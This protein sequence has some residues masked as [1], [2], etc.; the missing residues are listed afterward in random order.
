[1]F[2]R[3]LELSEIRALLRT[4]PVVTI[5]GPRQIGKTTL[6]REIARTWAG[7][8]TTFD[9]EDPR[10]VARL[11]DPT[12]ALAS[13][14]G[15]VVIDEIQ[16]RP[17]LFPVLRVLSDRDRRPAHFLLLGSASPLL[18]K[19][20][21]ESLAGRIVYVELRGFG[22]SD[23]GAR[24]ERLWLRGGYPRP[25]LA[26]TDEE[27]LRWRRD[28]I[29]TF[30]EQDLPQLGITI[31]AGTI[32]RFWMMLAHYHAQIWNGAEL[33]RAFGI[34]ES[35]V[36]RYL[37][38]LA[39]TFMVRVLP[40]WSENIGKRVVKTPKVY[41]ADTGL[42]HSLLD[43]PH[44]RALQAHPKIGAS[45][46]GFALQEVVR[47]LRARPEQ[48]YFWATHQA[49]ELD[50]LVIQ[51]ARR[52]GFEFKRTDAPGVTKS[53]HIAIQ[54]LGLESI[55]VVHAGGETYPLSTKIRALAISRLTTDLIP[56][57]RAGRR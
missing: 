42:L 34:A 40:P 41:V 36:K 17:D 53:M 29:R 57:R 28:L 18:L 2:G 7:P 32:H 24:W 12:M 3:A 20:S 26:R 50:L 56:A 16:R 25:Y 9:L 46:E 35:T 30:V 14:R 1:V 37:D 49:A 55:D 52:R 45:F 33:A 43:I 27:S 6:A 15:L 13:L 54:D 31:P 23:V 11:A 10:D 8:T 51:G 19:Q 47:A 44:A 22:L 38:L 48:C 21:S 5:L 4:N 39:N